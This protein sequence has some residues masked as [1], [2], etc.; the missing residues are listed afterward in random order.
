MST[1]SLNGK[2]KIRWSTGQRGGTPYVIKHLDDH[3]HMNEARGLPRE[4]PGSVR[5]AGM[6]WDAE[7]PGDVHLD[8]MRQGLLD[9]PYAGIHVFQ[10]RWVEECVWHYR[11]TFDAPEGAVNGRAAL[12]SRGWSSPPSS[13]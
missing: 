7:V 5:R 13:I 1:L 3:D 2:W 9:D 10:A 11:R 12:T 6:G 8:L 4:L